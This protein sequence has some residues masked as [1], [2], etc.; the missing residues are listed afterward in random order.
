MNTNIQYHQLN[1]LF[2]SMNNGDY[3]NSRLYEICE[4]HL[5]DTLVYIYTNGSLQGYLLNIVNVLLNNNPDGL[6]V[7]LKHVNQVDKSI[8]NLE[9]SN[10]N[11]IEIPILDYSIQIAIKYD[12]NGDIVRC[13]IRYYYIKNNTPSDITD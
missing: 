3:I 10:I 12:N 11:I 5:K 8:F 7:R 2:D 4:T 13:D 9:Q 1:G 6:G